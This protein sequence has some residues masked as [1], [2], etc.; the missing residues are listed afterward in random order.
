MTTSGTKS[1][2]TASGSYTIH[3]ASGAKGLPIGVFFSGGP[4]LSVAPERRHLEPL[5]R[6]HLDM[7]WFDQLGNAEAPAHSPES[8]TWR[9]LVDDAAHIIR[10]EAGGPVHVIAHCAGVFA[11]HGLVASHRELV[12]SATLIS[13]EGNAPL[14]FKSVLRGEIATGALNPEALPAALRQHLDRV[15]GSSDV[16][17]GKAEVDLILQLFAVAQDWFGLYWRDQTARAR[18]EDLG[19][20]API[21]VETFARLATEQFEKRE[22]LGPIYSDIPVHVIHGEGDPCTIW[23]EEAPHVMKLAPAAKVTMIS[24][25]HHWP[26]FERPE[27]T[28]HA[29]VAFIQEHS[30]S[31]KAWTPAGTKGLRK[32]L[33]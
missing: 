27:P 22:E 29:M 17:W 14:S 15:L 13:P 23:E 28:I 5:L 9:N 31:A 16:E 20:D 18:F 25:G 12:R 33:A 6:P 4:G 7:I 8:V 21:A 11:S 19:R 26:Y 30:T 1:I 2:R 10:Q 3:H 32:A 24:E